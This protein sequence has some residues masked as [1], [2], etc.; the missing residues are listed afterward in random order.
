[1]APENPSESRSRPRLVYAALQTTRPGQGGYAHVH[2]ILDGLTSLGWECTL[3][4]PQ[5]DHGSGLRG[6][7]RKSLEWVRI[8]RSASAAAR[9]A[10]FA[11]VRDHPAALP[12][13]RALRRR[14][15][16]TALEINGGFG[17]L[18]SQ[19]ALLRPFHALLRSQAEARVLSA[20]LVITVTRGLAEW[21]T[22]VGVARAPVVIP[23][24]A[25]TSAL[26]PDATTEHD[27]PRPYVIFLG[28]LAPWHGL[29][30]L[31]EAVDSPEWPQGVTLVIAGSGQQSDLAARA[32]NRNPAVVCLGHVPTGQVPGLL[33]GS[34]ASLSTQTARAGYAAG[35][36]VKVYEALSCGVPVI[37]SDYIEVASEIESARMGLSF[38]ADDSTGL[39]RAVAHLAQNPEEAAEMGRRARR[40]AEE[41]LDWKQRARQTE[42]ALESVRRSRGS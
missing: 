1:M 25:D 32:A 8:T 34:M 16:P 33:A 30:T 38:R 10:D 26:T 24:G 2:G 9:D 35:S 41:R 39:A 42:Q 19:F 18:S 37:A 28:S 20:T 22:G 29:G 21:A 4:D 36:P 7:L 6:L 17:E 40:Y 23:N 3:F 27:L 12:L 15:V 5:K 13:L 31:L 14:G 11:Y